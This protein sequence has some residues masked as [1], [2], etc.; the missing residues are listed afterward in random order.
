MGLKWNEMII[1]MIELYVQKIL[2]N[3]FNQLIQ[4]R[5]KVISL[6]FISTKF[7]DKLLKKWFISISIDNSRF[8]FMKFNKSLYIL[9]HFVMC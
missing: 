4:E 3:W 1:E 5:I 7:S 8:K 6:T 9:W 2:I